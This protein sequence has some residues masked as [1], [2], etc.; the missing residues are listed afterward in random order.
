[1]HISDE[2]LI[3]YLTLYEGRQ[4]YR[5][6]NGAEYTYRLEPAARPN[7]R[8]PYKIVFHSVE[9]EKDHEIAPCFAVECLDMY[10]RGLKGPEKYVA[11]TG[12]HS[13]SRRGKYML[14]LLRDVEAKMRS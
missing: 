12:A 14:E 2:A 4:Y 10:N 9:W 5:R 7:D 1:M 8:M 11:K 3:A 6:G 13:P